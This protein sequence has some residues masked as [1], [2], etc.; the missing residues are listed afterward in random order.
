[1]SKISA[2]TAAR[3]GLVWQQLHQQPRE[4]EALATEVDRDQIFTAR[5]RMT[6]RVERM[7]HTADSG[8]PLSQFG[9]GRDPVGDSGHRDLLPGAGQPLGHGGLGGEHDGGDFGGGQLAERAQG[10]SQPGLG[11]QARMAAGEDQPEEIVCEDVLGQLI[12]SA[13]VHQL[14][15]RS[16]LGQAG[17]LPADDVDCLP[18]AGGDQPGPRRIGYSMKLP[19]PK[20][21]DG[22]LLHRLLGDGKVTDDPGEG[23]QQPGPLDPDGLRQLVACV[24]P[25]F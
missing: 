19:I 9:I 18:P 23:G 5:R 7:H 11:S 8:K 15:P 13:L 16:F 2:S 10:E 22:C 6:R 3:H 24:Q 4:A 12:R 1:M 14:H 20:S 25:R 21:S 17:T